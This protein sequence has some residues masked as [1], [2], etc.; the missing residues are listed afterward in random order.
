M[1]S[2][3]LA[4]FEAATAFNQDIG[5]KQELDK[6]RDSPLFIQQVLVITL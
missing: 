1:S 3:Y 4:I 5:P 2:Y 6:V